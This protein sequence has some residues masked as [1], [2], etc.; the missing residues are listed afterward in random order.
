MS[1]SKP[2]E[3]HIICATGVGKRFVLYNK[4]S[5]RL[6]E[7]I[8]AREP[9]SSQEFWALRNID[10]RINRG[11]VIGIIGNNGAG[12]ST[13][14]Q[15]ICGTLKPTVGSLSVDGRVTALLELGAGFNPDFS[16]RENIF[17]NAAILG[18]HR[19]TL[20]RDLQ[21]IIAFAD[22]GAFI[23]HPVRT[24]SSGMFMRLAFAVATS[25]QPDIL[26]IDEALSVGDGAFARKSFERI[27]ALKEAGVTI[28]F[29]SHAMYQV[30]ALCSRVLWLEQ[31]QIKEDGLPAHVTRDYKASLM[32]ADAVNDLLEERPEKILKHESSLAAKGQG[33]FTSIEGH[34]EFGSGRVLQARSKESRLQIDLHFRIDPSLPK[35]SLALGI[36]DQSGITIAS[37]TSLN[38]GVTI[39]VDDQGCGHA[40]IIFPRLPLLKGR[41]FI[42]L[43]L[44]CERMLHIYDQATNYLS[45]EV[46]Q[47]GLEQGFVHLPHQWQS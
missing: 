17:M 28:L 38:D 37:A 6:K 47:D 5:D 23:D 34:T 45:L 24:Y 15:L 22:I 44:A 29:C 39:F 13:L 2:H 27:M 35:P 4:P 33:H 21:Q 11:E 40:Q 12:K 7:I 30:E 41:Y 25:S 43:F 18:I 1:S 42:T 31:G 8:F 19:D 26:I 3:A 16:G 32:K 46:T 10:L 14:L 9:A 36:N 20:E